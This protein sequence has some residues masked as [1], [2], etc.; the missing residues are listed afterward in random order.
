[1]DEF[2]RVHN[3]K[4]SGLFL[5]VVL[6]DYIPDSA[7]QH[8]IR[9]NNRYNRDPCKLELRNQSNGSLE[10]GPRKKAEAKPGIAGPRLSVELWDRL[11]TTPYGRMGQPSTWTGH[12]YSLR[13]QAR[14][15]RSTC[16]AAAQSLPTARRP[17]ACL[18]PARSRAL[19][20]R[21]PRER[22]YTAPKPPLPYHEP[23]R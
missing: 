23:S 22:P 15:A 16:P 9:Y 8:A 14:G 1:M 17:S 6:P 20:A 13:N 10:A 21:P 2:I 11:D 19:V 4:T 12:K 5:N 18:R 3:S 7:H